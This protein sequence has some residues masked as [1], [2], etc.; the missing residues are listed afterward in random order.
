MRCFFLDFFSA[1]CFDRVFTATAMR[2]QQE[3]T[4]MPLK[5]SSNLY[6]VVFGKD[7]GVAKTVSSSRRS[8]LS[9]RLSKAILPS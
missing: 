1:P 2:K 7:A 6:T 9:H 8:D 4:M 3:G 5:D